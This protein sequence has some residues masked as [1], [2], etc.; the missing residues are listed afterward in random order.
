MWC[1]ST[2]AWLKS[3]WTS[4]L[5]DIGNATEPSCGAVTGA[6][7]GFALTSAQLA[8]VNQERIT[9]HLDRKRGGKYS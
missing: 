1:S 8:S 6:R 3:D 4:G 7:S 9:R 5:Q 2:T